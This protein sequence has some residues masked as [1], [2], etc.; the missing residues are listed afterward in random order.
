[1]SLQELIRN[2]G[3]QLN[4]LLWM[5]K[6]QP[7]VTEKDMGLVS[8]FFH[9]L[10]FEYQWI[11]NPFPLTDDIRL[12]VNDLPK[13]SPVRIS[14][15]PEPDLVLKR[16]RDGKGIY[17]EAKASLA[18]TCEKDKQTRGHLLANGPAFAEVL[19]PLTESLLCYVL[20]ESD[21]DAMRQKLDV[22]TQELAGMGF[23]PGKS[24]VHGFSVEGN[25]IVYHWDAPFAQH[26]GNLGRKRQEAI[27]TAL[28]DGNEPIHLL[29]VYSIEDYPRQ[30][31][32]D[33]YREAF[34][35]RVQQALICDMRQGTEAID[36]GYVLITD[37]LLMHA[38]DKVF[39]YLG[40][41]RQRE[42]RHLV[43]ANFFCRIEGHYK[44]KNPEMLRREDGR[45][46][47][48]FGSVAEREEFIDWLERLDFKNIEVPPL[49]D[50][51]PLFES[52]GVPVPE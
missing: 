8:P 29:L 19:K 40:K 23:R 24:S 13:D 3:Y 12:Q 1:M 22:L 14:L 34:L 35:R 48:L 46:I 47:F 2:P 26:V 50:G 10:G 52:A 11:E 37:T 41:K 5:A 43:R 6:D 38:T 20:P 32:C 25:K 31:Y 16:N 27:F 28:E 36:G 18:A 45:L 17:L 4:L 9:K 7:E 44:G 39:N 51:L 15:A 30:E 42:L 21:R 49:A 33:Y